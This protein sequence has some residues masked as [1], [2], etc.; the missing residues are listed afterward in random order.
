MTDAPDPAGRIRSWHAHV[1]F[2]GPVQRA[3]AEVLRQQIAQ[4]F[5]VQL[6]R[7]RDA[8]VGPHTRSMYMVA[9]APERFAELV[10]FL[11]L[12]RQGLDVLVHPNTLAP[13]DDHLVHAF[14]LGNRLPVKA[15][16]LPMA[17]SADEDEVLEINNW[18]ARSG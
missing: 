5:E 7:W 6:G 8:L 14:W 4:R 17:V 15:E 11:A 10:P 3:A 2:D 1:Y 18:P 12:N 9:F 13:R 16:V